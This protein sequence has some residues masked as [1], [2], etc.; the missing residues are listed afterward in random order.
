VDARIAG[1][2][3]NDPACIIYTSGTSGSPKGVVLSH[4][5]ILRNVDGAAEVLMG[6]FGWDDERFVSFLPLSHALEHTAGLYLPIALG[7]DI[8]FSEGLDKLFTN[9]EEAQPTFMIVVP[10][11]FEV[12]RDRIIRQVEKQ[13]RFAN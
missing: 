9:I 8:W 13:G 2:K 3:R 12:L 4:G 6:D 1:I 5:A 7:A 11:L 10:R